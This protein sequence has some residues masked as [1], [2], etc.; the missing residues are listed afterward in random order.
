MNQDANPN[1]GSRSEDQSTYR[2]Q[3]KVMQR[4]HAF[5]ALS[6]QKSDM[7]PHFRFMWVVR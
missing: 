4:D 2:V 1:A 6:G 5:P 7:P 3:G